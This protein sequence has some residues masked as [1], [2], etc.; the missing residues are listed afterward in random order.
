MIRELYILFFINL[1][2]ST[3]YSQTFLDNTP[4]RYFN[5][6]LQSKYENDSTIKANKIKRI[7]Y[8]QSNSNS[9]LKRDT[10]QVR[11]YNTE[12]QYIK[13]INYNNNQKS[14]QYIFTRNDNTEKRI[15]KKY[16]NNSDKIFDG[17]SEE[18]FTKFKDEKIVYRLVKHIDG[19]DK[20]SMEYK[21]YYNGLKLTKRENIH[22]N[23]TQ[24]VF[25]YTYNNEEKLINY[26]MF[27]FEKSHN[28]E[29]KQTISQDVDYSY[30]RQNNLIKVLSK[31]HSTYFADNEYYYTYDQDNK[32]INERY[33]ISLSKLN[34]ERKAGTINY[35]YKND[36]MLDKIIEKSVDNDILEALFSYNKN[37]NISTIVCTFIS[38]DSGKFILFNPSSKKGILKYDYFYDTKNNVSKMIITENNSIRNIYETEIEYY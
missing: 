32:I 3:S 11:E 12:G 2:Y 36:R 16:Y 33:N 1:L 21:Y 34:D 25:N 31:H 10:T 8:F 18:T 27:R 26:N 23:F 29:I 22:R 13:L 37:D 19:N 4:S 5:I 15:Y 20:D 38:D 9:G 24:V 14:T 17:Y 6:F 7:T 35:L 28:N 30:D